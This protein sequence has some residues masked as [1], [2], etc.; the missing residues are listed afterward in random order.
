MKI[1]LRRIGKH[2]VNRKTSEYASVKQ[3][4]CL[5]VVLYKIHG[6]R[7]FILSSPKKFGTS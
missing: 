6:L 4:K 2:I 1:G 3:W 7:L 5:E